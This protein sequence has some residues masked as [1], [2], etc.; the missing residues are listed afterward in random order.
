MIALCQPNNTFIYDNRG[1][2]LHKLS[3]SLGVQYL[4]YHFLLVLYD[5]RKLKYYDTTTGYIVAE[6][7]AKNHYTYMTQNKS[8]A[9]IAM[10]TGKGVV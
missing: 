10:G 6:H 5:N 3:Q 1:I 9:V 8:N 7:L 4:P 2:E